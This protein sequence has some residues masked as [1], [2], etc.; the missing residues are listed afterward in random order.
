MNI[1]PEGCNSINKIFA[2]YIKL[3][4]GKSRQAVGIDNSGWLMFQLSTNFA[5]FWHCI[6]NV[7][8]CPLLY[9]TLIC[10]KNC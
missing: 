6:L 10:I 7:Y 3:F 9:P 8:I 5:F 2:I 4:V 1:V